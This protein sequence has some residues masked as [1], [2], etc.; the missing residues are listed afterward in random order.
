VL[1]EPLAPDY[2]FPLRSSTSTTAG[3]RGWRSP[4]WPGSGHTRIAQP[5]RPH[6]SLHRHKP[7][8][9]VPGT[10]MPT[11]GLAVDEGT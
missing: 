7:R 3:A 2:S 9:A 11:P 4:T 5:R 10:G 6:E 1:N 8:C